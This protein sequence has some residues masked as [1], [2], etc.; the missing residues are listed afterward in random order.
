MVDSSSTYIFSRILRRVRPE[1]ARFQ[2]AEIMEGRTCFGKPLLKSDGKEE[3]MISVNCIFNN[4]FLVQYSLNSI[5]I[6]SMNITKAA[7]LLLFFG[8]LMLSP[9]ISSAETINLRSGNGNF[10]E[11]DKYVNMLVG[12]ANS[13]FADVFTLA[14][15]TDAKNGSDAFI[16]APHPAWGG[17]LPDDT[18]SKWI[19]TNSGGAGEGSTAMYAISF[20]VFMP[21]DSAS[22]D[23]HLKADNELGGGPNEGVYLN[24]IALAGTSGFGE[25]PL[26][27][28]IARND[29]GSILV[30]GEN[31]LYINA[32]DVGGP[33]G[34]LFRATIETTTG[35]V[36]EPVTAT[37]F[38]TGLAALWALGRRKLD[39]C[40]VNGKW[41]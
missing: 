1:T 27:T 2:G 4:C 37:L 8:T 15:F 41:S 34:L 36:P 19:S 39:E 3:V 38:G 28:V 31:T 12:P 40:S 20:F 32:T 7:S 25:F 10:G 21:F 11:N 6:N 24:G 22:I 13:A 14:N 33:S 17:G 5:H 29:I 23:L 30:P 16:V 35:V 26:E 18:I 9:G